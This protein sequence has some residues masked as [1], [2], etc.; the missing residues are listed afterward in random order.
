M[1]IVHHHQFAIGKS[2]NIQLD[3][4]R[5]N[6]ARSPKCRK[7]VLGLAARGTTMGDDL[8]ITRCCHH[9]PFPNFIAKK[10]YQRL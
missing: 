8:W 5:A 3:C 4:I 1:R 10:V 2:P 9:L 6:V 7:R